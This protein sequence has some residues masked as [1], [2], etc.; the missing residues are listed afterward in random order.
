[1]PLRHEILVPG[2]KDFGIGSTGGGPFSPDLGGPCGQRGVDHPPD[3]LPQRM[4]LD[5]TAAHVEQM[6]VT[7]LLV[8]GDQPFQTGIGTEAI[9]TT[10]Q[11]GLS[12]L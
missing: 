1:M 12:G 4:S 10:Q 3:R 8:R 2:P 5:K 9:E 7:D 6:R 11:P